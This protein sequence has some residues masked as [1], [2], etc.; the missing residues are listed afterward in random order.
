MGSIRKFVPFAIR[1]NMFTGIIESIGKVASLQK[2]KGNL[3]IEIE[4]L[5]SAQLKI[6][7][8]V[9]HNGVCLTVSAPPTLR[10]PGSRSGSYYV[11]AVKETLSKTNLGL[12]KRGSTVNLERALMIGDRLDGH[13]VQGHVDTTAV[14]K[15][16]KKEKGSWLFTFQLDREKPEARKLIVN[17]GSICING[18]SLTVM[19]IFELQTSGRGFSFSVAIIPHTF[20]HTNFNKLK[21]GDRVNIEFDILGKYIQTITP[22]AIRTT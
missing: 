8:S 2:E 10:S 18:V 1:K 13:F 5:F 12:L 22:V 11:I 21:K 17:K 19:E 16:R 15:K 7:Q 3:R 6:G 14:C 9:A 20:K 4:S